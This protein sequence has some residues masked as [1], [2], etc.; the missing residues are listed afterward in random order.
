MMTLTSLTLALAFLQASGA[1]SEVDARPDVVVVLVDTLRPDHLG[2][3][4][5]ELETAPYLAEL[6]EEAS[7]FKNCF[8]TTS[9]T[10]PAVASLFSGL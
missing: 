9:W 10:A 3:L 7:V 6:A 2:F 5:H 4:G 8:S 1:S